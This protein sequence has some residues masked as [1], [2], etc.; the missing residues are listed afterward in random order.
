MKH[1][2]PTITAI[3]NR[4]KNLEET[5]DHWYHLSFEANDP[6][7]KDKFNFLGNQCQFGINE[8]KSLIGEK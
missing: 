6:D 8:L 5:R 4:I 7:E 2:R 1:N 3:L